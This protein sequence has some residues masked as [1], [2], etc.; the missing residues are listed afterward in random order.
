[1]KGGWGNQTHTVMRHEDKTL[2]QLL[3]EAKIEMIYTPL[4]KY[5]H[6]RLDFLEYNGKRIN[7]PRHDRCY[8]VVLREFGIDLTTFN[9]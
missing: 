9:D 8:E 7:R 3:K 1:M 6:K 4:D 5:P 2:I